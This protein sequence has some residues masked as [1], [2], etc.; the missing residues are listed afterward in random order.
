[1]CSSDL[2]GRALA[3]SGDEATTENFIRVGR[4]LLKNGGLFFLCCRAEP[5]AGLLEILR[6]SRLEP[7]RMRPV[8]HAP[9]REANLLLLECRAGARPGLTMESPFFLHGEHG[10]ETEE[11]RR[12]CHR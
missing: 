6:A 9:D 8:Y 4:R 5:L 1:M 2:A 3:R 7:K 12:I 10:E 11:Y